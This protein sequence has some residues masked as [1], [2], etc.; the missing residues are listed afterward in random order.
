[1]QIV[2][3]AITRKSYSK[4][5]QWQVLTFF[6]CWVGIPSFCIGISCKLFSLDSIHLFYSIYGRWQ[7]ILTSQR[8]YNGVKSCRISI[9]YVC[10]VILFYVTPPPLNN[11][12][13]WR[14]AGGST[15]SRQSQWTVTLKQRGQG[16]F[17]ISRFCISLK[18][19]K[20]LKNFLF[21]SDHF[22]GRT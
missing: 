14:P 3:T 1:M 10:V 19:G 2:S 5:G 20:E 12:T 4:R 18:A 16:T 21:S 7:L 22:F 6:C 17:G 11:T 9:S 13:T 8:K 15:C